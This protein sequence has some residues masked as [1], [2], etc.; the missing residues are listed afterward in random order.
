MPLSPEEFDQIYSRVT[1]L[2]VEVVIRSDQG[3]LLVKRDIE[4]CRGQWHLPGGT[5]RFGESLIAAVRR[6]AMAEVG[7][8]VEVGPQ[9]GYIEYPQMLAGGYRGWPVGLAFEAT[10]AGGRITGSPAGA[11]A[12]WF[13]G[14]PQVTIAEQAEFLA[15]H[16]AV[17]VR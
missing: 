13:T 9:I 12:A 5:V 17:P 14:I 15:R 16:L 4:P 7:V 8:T 2:T 10:V 6:V 11:E 1:R 3:I